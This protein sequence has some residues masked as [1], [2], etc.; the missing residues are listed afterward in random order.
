MSIQT[1]KNEL[2]EHL[3]ERINDGV[4]NEDNFDDAHHHAFNEDYYIIGYHRAEQ[5]LKRHDVSAFEAI[6]IC[7]EYERDNFGEVSKDYDNAET[8]VNML[9]YVMGHD[10]TPCAGD[11]EEFKADLDIESENSFIGFCN[12]SVNDLKENGYEYVSD[13]GESMVIL[14]YG[15][16]MLEAFAYRRNGHASWGIECEMGSLEFCHDVESGE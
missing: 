5:W 10:V 16:D 14:R 7:I 1:I 8:T 11:W 6:Q 2:R 9:A 15:D 4:I 12:I 3:I 13:D